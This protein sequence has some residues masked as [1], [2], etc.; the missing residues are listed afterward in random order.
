MQ[1]LLLQGL[2]PTRLQAMISHL[3]TN[4]E[5]W[6]WLIKGVREAKIKRSQ[7]L[8]YNKRHNI[9]SDIAPVLDYDPAL[10]CLREAF[11][12]QKP[13]LNRFTFGAAIFSLPP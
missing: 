5:A 8:I 12:P 1:V 3:S 7:E 4:D 11:D 13:P 10:E 2:D 6:S 9:D